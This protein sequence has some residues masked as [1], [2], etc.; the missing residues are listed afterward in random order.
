MDKV[1]LVK[2]QLKLEHWRKLI[3]E[4]Q[5]SG[6]KVK[7]W[8]FQNNV[9]KDQYYYWLRKVREMTVANMPMPA[10]NLHAA[11]DNVSFKQLEVKSPVTC[12]MPGVIIHLPQATI[13][14]TDGVSQSTVEAVILALK[15]TC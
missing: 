6:L 9:S 5:A 4:C 13:E 8:C 2:S 3:A 7:Q 12:M 10:D 15:S 1:S 11:N 14:V